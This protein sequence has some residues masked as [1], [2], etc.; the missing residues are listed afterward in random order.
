LLK[1]WCAVHRSQLAWHS[2]SESVIELKHC[3]Q[4]LIRLVL[5]F[6]TSG[7]R[8]REM[9]KIAEEN[10]FNLIRL[11]TVFE[12]RW[13]EFSFT[14]LNAVLTSWQALVTF[15]QNSK[16]VSARGHYK[17]LTLVSNLRLLAFVADV[18]FVFGRFQKRLQSD[19]TTLIDMHFAVAHV[20]SALVA[21]KQKPLLGGWQETFEE[22]ATETDGDLFLKGI[23]LS[24]ATKRREQHHLFVTDKRSSAAVCNEIIKWVTGLFVPLTIRTTDFSYH[25]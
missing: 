16:E 4:N 13:T 2:V 10:V 8:N 17:F 1:V 14:L 6:H 18:L 5:Y 15:L 7:V 25:V 11:P 12:V 3:F 22:S 23:Q 20:Q 9:K 24:A 21:L 19:K